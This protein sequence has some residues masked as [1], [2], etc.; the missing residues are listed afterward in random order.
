MEKLPGRAA[1]ANRTRGLLK[2][3]R[4]SEL[5]QR[6]ATCADGEAINIIISFA[7]LQ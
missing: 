2:I 3:L 1:C 6:R 5:I 4:G 7:R